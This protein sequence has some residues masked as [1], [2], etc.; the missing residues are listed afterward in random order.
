[1]EENK[2]EQTKT[3][4]N[5]LEQIN[6]V[7]KV[8]SNL[9]T[10]NKK[11]KKKKKVK[12]WV[13]FL[14]VFCIAIVVLIGVAFAKLS[15]AMS[16]MGMPV[17][18]AEALKGD[19]AQTVETSGVVASEET[20]VY[21]ADVTAKVDQISVSQ[22][23]MVKKGDMLL[24]YDVTDLEKM[25]KQSELETKV[26]TLGADAAIVGV[27]AAQKKASEAATN[28]EDA[29][30]YVAHYTEC[31]GQ[32]S[33]QLQE[34]SELTAQQTALAAEIKKLEKAVGDNPED[35]ASAK[36]LKAAK[37]EYNKVTKQL[38][39]YDVK[40]LQSTLEVCSGDLAEY[41]ALLK[42][43]EMTKE[44]DPAASLTIAQQ[45]ASKEMAQLSKKSVE[46]QLATA[47]EGVK[48]DFDGVVSE[49]TAVQGQTAAEG[50]QLFT[51]HNT[52]KLKVNLSVTK[53]DVQKLA[54]GQ[55]AE[56][57]INDK[58]YT[59][60]VSKI[61]RIASVN[62]SGAAVVDVE[63]HIDNP[64][65]TVILGM[66][67]K[68]SVHTAEEKD[69]LLIPSASV[70]YSSEGIFCYVLA[71]GKIEKREIETGISDEE[72]IQVLSGV[73][74]G[75]KV[76]TNVTGTIEEGMPATEMKKDAMMGTD[77]E[78]AEEKEEAEE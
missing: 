19:I 10:D 77:A 39:K 13:I 54:I 71:D 65:D 7:I 17:E 56:I 57:K 33:A 22:G 66:E 23:Q 15:S 48:A 46:E 14:I 30:K 68:V 25:L 45:A 9:L 43:Y 4:Q 74:E 41:K 69:I 38:E 36:A 52:D 53:Y 73:K 18:V 24:S 28:Y 58:E 8:D 37:K 75:D 72:F 51:I 55:T 44:G 63:I 62:A 59:G 11:E 78:E 40:Q 49:V 3:E 29:K 2:T 12:P 35:K 16:R 64:D 26:S 50:V 31:V 6:E 20:K 61:S 76:V 34:A 32:A 42:E 5:K 67:A 1:M 70:N 47:K 21:F 60:S 27:N